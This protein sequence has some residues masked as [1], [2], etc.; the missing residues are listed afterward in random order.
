MTDGAGS[1]NYTYDSLDRLTTAT[2]PGGQPNESYTYDDVGNRTLSH[3][4]SN[5]TYQAFNSLLSANGASAGYDTNGSQVSKTD[6]SGS[7]VYSWDFENRLKQASLSGGVVVNYGYDALGRR[8]NRSSSVNGTTRFLYDGA[9]VVRDLDASNVT[10]SEYLYGLAVDNKLRQITGASASYFIADHLGSTRALADATGSITS[11]IAYDSF[12]NVA[13]GS[14]P[15]RYTYTG[16]EFDSDTGQMHYR[17]REYNLNGGRFLS[18][19]PIGLGGGI[20]LYAYVGN[21]P[22]RF[23]DPSGTQAR[24]DRSFNSGEKSPTTGERLSNDLTKAGDMWCAL[25]GY[26]PWLSLDVAGG[27]HLLSFLGGNAGAGVKIQPFTLQVCFYFRR[28]I[29]TGF[30]IYLGGGLIGGLGLGPVDGATNGWATPQGG[31]DVAVPGAA[32]R[33]GG[34]GGS[35]SGGPGGLGVGVGP[36]AGAG[37]SFGVDICYYKTVCFNKPKCC[38]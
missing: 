5:Y 33:L 26:N 11:S 12:G 32:G 35:A 24:S 19:D 22:I 17:A 37:G 14:V 10:I 8:V 31:A 20:N 7:W 2:H 15:T 3:Q 1:H 9:D 21:N 30:G 28:C 34:R 27:I 6:A 38:K 25:D 29:R 36:T 13:A 4:A 16:R 23:L 18:E